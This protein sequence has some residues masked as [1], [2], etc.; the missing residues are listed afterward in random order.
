MKKLIVFLLV[1]IFN[2]GCEKDKSQLTSQEKLEDFDFLYMELEASYPYFHINERLNN[3]DWLS[4]RNIYQDQILKTKNDK[5]FLK[6]LNSILDDLNNDHTDIYPTLNYNY[7]L[8]AYQIGFREYGLYKSYIEELEKTDT[9][10]TNYWSS[11]DKELYEIEAISEDLGE[12]KQESNLTIEEKDSIAIIKIR[13][14]SYDLIE[15]DAKRLKMFFQKKLTNYSTLIIDIQGNEGGDTSYWSDNIVNYLIK[16]TV[17]YTVNY[18]F[19]NSKRIREFKPSYFEKTYSYEDLDLNQV[20]QEIKS[21]EYLIYSTEA[22]IIPKSKKRYQGNVFLVVDKDVYSSAEAL[23]HFFKT[24]KIGIVVGERTNGDG[25][26]T[27][28]LLLTLPNSG[29]V[30]RFT[31]EMGLNP[32]GSANEEMKTTP[33]VLIKANSREERLNHL[34]LQIKEN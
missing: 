33:D 13:S 34:L 20:P 19:K 30:I 27:D 15:E 7:F 23:A 5:D 1:V 14:F 8:K 32:D 26:G 10:K 9:I 11:I 4:R 21:D 31:G 16:D 2:S 22:K 17:K 6:A 29:I 18:A 28:P 25:V 24:T 3:I 12:T